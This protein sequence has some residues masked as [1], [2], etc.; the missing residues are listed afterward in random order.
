MYVHVLNVTGSSD[1]HVNV[2]VNVNVQVGVNVCACVRVH[3]AVNVKVAVNVNAYEH[4]NAAEIV[5][6][7]CIC[8]WHVHVYVLYANFYSN[9]HVHA[10]ANFS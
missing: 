6:V 10:D 8:L 9:L 3:V 5:H 4:V 2:T 7:S 1:R